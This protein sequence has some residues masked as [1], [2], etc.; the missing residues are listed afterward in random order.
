M[1][2]PL[3]KLFYERFCCLASNGAIECPMHGMSRFV[4]AEK[5]YPFHERTSF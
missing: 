4:N 3:L 5:N 1:K 2:Q